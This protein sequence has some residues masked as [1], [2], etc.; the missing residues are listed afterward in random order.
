MAT[1]EKRELTREEIEAAKRLKKAWLI[2]R[3]A[4]KTR[5]GQNYTQALLA[6]EAGMNGQSIVGQYLNGSIQ[7]NLKA[8]LAI[9]SVIKANPNEIAPFL[10]VTTDQESGDIIADF[11]GGQKQY[12]KAY[13]SAPKFVQEAADALLTLP[14]EKQREAGRYIKY[15]ADSA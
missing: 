4:N 14:E 8:L 12:V 13:E 1:V 9:C 11:F 10:M 3:D 15:L 2:F 7:L 5:G 6:K